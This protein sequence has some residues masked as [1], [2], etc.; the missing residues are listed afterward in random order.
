MEKIQNRPKLLTMIGILALLVLSVVIPQYHA[1]AATKTIYVTKGESVKISVK[2]A[3]KKTKW[4]CSNKKR[5]QVKRGKGKV[6]VKG[7]K[8]GTVTIKS[9]IRKKTKRY[10]IVVETPKINKKSLTLEMGKIVQL[11]MTQTKRK[12]KWKSSNSDIVYVSSRTGKVAAVEP[13]TADVY[14]VIGKKKYICKITVPG[15]AKGTTDNPVN[16]TPAADT[17]VVSP[18]SVNPPSQDTG[19]YEITEKVTYVTKGDKKIYGKLY[20]PVGTGDFPAI[21]LAHGFNGIADD[22]VNECRY[23]AKNGYIAYAYDFCG[24]SGRSR[25]TGKTTDM[26]IFTEKQDVL[27]VFDFIYNMDGVDKE[28][29]YLFGGSQGGLVTALAAEERVEQVKAMALYFPAFNIPND[30]RNMYPNP[31]NLGATIDFWGLTLGKEFVVSMHEFDPFENI[32][33]F[34]KNVY[35]LHGDKDNIVALSNSQKAVDIYPNA[36]LRVMPGEGHGFTPASGKIAMEEVLKFME[37]NK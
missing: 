35:I 29:V 27:D 3:T 4:S 31:E 25:S 13:G 23:Y 28:R 12:P 15:D 37:Q 17:P 5:V 30:W 11:K 20:A 8:K 34:N 36:S 7:K 22:F 24:G 6:T 9:K 21:I 33:S 18:P 19:K 2:G 26:T 1:E 14:T 32:G 16:N 10:K